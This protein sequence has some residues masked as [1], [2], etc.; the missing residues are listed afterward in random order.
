[1]CTIFAGQD[2]KNYECQTRSIRL[3]GHSTSVRLERMFWLV[4]DRIA[5]SQG[6]NTGK[7]LST[8]YDEALDINGD[9]SNFASLLRCSCLLYLNA[10]EQTMHIANTELKIRKLTNN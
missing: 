7:F 3:G 10:P 6:M 4:I 2:P 1:M 5:N 9:V 8:I